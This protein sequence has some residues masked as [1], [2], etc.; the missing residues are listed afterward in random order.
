ML[1]TLAS[2]TFWQIKNRIRVRIARLKEPRYLIGSIAGLAY[3]TYFAI[4]RN[5][6]PSRFRAAGAANFLRIAGPIEIG[7]AL[8]LLLLAA[9]VWVLPAAG[10]PLRFSHS[11][12][13][14]L[15]PAPITR[16]QLVQ[17]RLLRAQLGLL[18]GSV[19]ATVFMRPTTFSN[20]WKFV[21]GLWLILMTCR[22]YFTGVSL[23]R[24]GLRQRGIG[25]ISKWAPVAIVCA[26]AGLVIGPIYSNW[27]WLSTAGGLQSFFDG[28][29][30]I[31]SSGAVPWILW[32]FR[33]LTRLPLAATT[34]AYLSALPGALAVLIVNYLWVLSADTAFE[35]NAALIAEKQP[36]EIARRAQPRVKGVAAT[37]FA[38]AP[39]GRL[40]TAIVW[41]NLIMVGRYASLRTL[42]RLAPLVIT[43]GL[44]IS[45]ASGRKEMATFGAMLCLVMV[46]NTVLAG[47]MVARNDL[48]RDL[49]NLAMLK[50]WPVSGATL[51]RGEILAPAAM[52][53][54]IAWLFILGAASLSGN[55]SVRFLQP[56]LQDRFSYVAAAVLLAPGLILVELTMLNGLAVMFPAWIS[57]GASRS[58][59]VDAVGQ[60]LFTTAG[61]VLTLV[62]ALLP[63][64]IVAGLVAGGFY[65]LTGVLLIVIPSAIITSVLL[66]ECFLVVEMLGRVLDRTDVSAVSPAE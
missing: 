41:K 13:Q 14:F 1:S 53:T 34:T 30:R 56:F 16:R 46:A 66:L 28:L 33:A 12:I 27:S 32:P 25:G 6:G 26:A 37:P 11:E 54:S 2:L 44:I 62:I 58:R 15:F 59:G 45:F 29:D 43:V 24:E 3:I 64:T 22:I 50:A 52:L 31:T 39:T 9:V 7:A 57:T 38:L 4:L 47:P 51:L 42:L 20:S 40:E 63:A 35:E 36:G 8:L 60:R 55:L 17:Y 49:G 48:R 19:M 65:F 18:F 61:V 5:G 23:Y 21:T 10:S